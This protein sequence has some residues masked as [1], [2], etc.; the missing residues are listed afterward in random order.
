MP[1]GPRRSEH[2]VPQIVYSVAIG[3]REKA[4]G[5]KK[6]TGWAAF[7]DTKNFPGQRSCAGIRSMRSRW[8]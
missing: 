3:W 4:F 2:W 1:D 7:W 8:R 6:P 5:D